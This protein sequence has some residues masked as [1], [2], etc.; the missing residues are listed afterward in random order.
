[1][2][3]QWG[4]ESQKDIITTSFA[5]YLLRQGYTQDPKYSGYISCSFAPLSSKL[6]HCTVFFQLGI[7]TIFTL[8][9]RNITTHPPKKNW[10]QNDPLVYHFFSTSLGGKPPLSGVVKLGSRSNPLKVTLTDRLNEWVDIGSPQ[11]TGRRGAWPI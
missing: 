7:L 2:I 10:I 5:A 8:Y 9:I 3:F 1:M 4:E 6:L 11:S